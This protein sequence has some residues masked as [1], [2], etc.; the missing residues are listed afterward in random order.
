M[1]YEGSHE[2]V[3]ISSFLPAFNL[4]G[5]VLDIAEWVSEWYEGPEVDN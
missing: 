5:H 4:R 1:K 2:Y 3:D